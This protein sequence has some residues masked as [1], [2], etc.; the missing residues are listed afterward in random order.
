MSRRSM[1]FFFGTIAIT[2]AIS[3]VA[4]ADGPFQ[5]YAVTPCRL[6]N[7][8]TTD[9]PALV[10]KAA[11]RNFAVWNTAGC[12]IPTGAKAVTVNLAVVA[13]TGGG[14]IRLWPYGITMPTVAT[15][16]FDPNEPAISNGAVV[17][18]GTDPTY[19]MSAWG[20]FGNYNETANIV[21]DV[22]GYFAP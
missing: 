11:A 8:R 16:N 5:Y 15:I 12:G 20:A 4:L 17:P 3:Q 9:A 13:P 18:L 2:A 14:N 21:I 1:G 6:I 22:T 10:S 19:Q 7:T